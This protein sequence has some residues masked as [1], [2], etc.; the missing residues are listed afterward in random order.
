MTKLMFALALTFLGTMLLAY[1]ASAAD[2]EV[3]DDPYRVEEFTLAT[4]GNLEVKTSGG[5]ITVEG[6][7]TDRLRVEMYVRKNGKDL[8]PEDTDLA[9]YD[10]EISKSGNTVHAV[11]KRA[12]DKGWRFWNNQPSISFVVYTP[13]EM[14]TDLKTS[15]GH[16]KARGLDGE[17][18]ISTSGG[19]LELHELKGVVHARTSGGHIDIDSFNGE[20]EAKTSGGHIEARASEG[21]IHLRTSGGHIEL[22]D[23][24]GSIKASTSGGSISA[25]LKSIGQYVDLRTSGGSINIS[26]PEGAGLDLDLKGTRVQTKLLNFSGE[27]EDDKV[28]G[29]INGGGPKLSARTSG[30]RVRISFH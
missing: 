6:S 14:S 23:L 2:T 18:N 27:V 12:N 9:G 21:S 19:H 28:E 11:A 13:R 15:G 17:Q 20:M 10:I 4:P 29:T 22:D 5:H 1:T 7:D 24:S 26:V 30:G 3:K 16:I 8:T 25:D